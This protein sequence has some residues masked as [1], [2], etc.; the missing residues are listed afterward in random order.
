MELEQARPAAKPPLK[1]GA[2]VFL[3]Q[4]FEGVRVPLNGLRFLLRHRA[5][6]GYAILPL[7]INLTVTLMVLA[8]VGGIGVWTAMW[9]HDLPY[10][11]ANGWGRTQEVFADI[12]L[13]AAL[14]GMAAGGYLL[15]GGIL[16]SFFNERLAQQTEIVLGDAPAQIAVAPFAQHVADGLRAFLVV[17]LTTAGCFTLGCIPGVGFVVGAVSLC[18]DWFIFGYEFFEMPLTLRGMRRTEK[19]AFAREHRPRVL[20]MGAAVFLMNMIP[21]VGGVF[22]TTAAV[23]AVLLHRKLK[24]PPA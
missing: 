21:L 4:F 20:G 15:L 11:A 3:N 8:A 18:I 14:L 5:L 6:L 23:G 10:F 9:F 19:R 17:M 16:S 1:A 24:E 2:R 7:L 12:A 22:L 13:F